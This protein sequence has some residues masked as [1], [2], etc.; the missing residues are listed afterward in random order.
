MLFSGY[1]GCGNPGDEAILQATVD[2][3]RKEGVVD[4][5]VLSRNLQEASQM[6]LRG[7]LRES[8]TGVLQGISR[9]RVLMSGGGGLLQ[10]STG[11]RSLLYYLGIIFL[12]KMMGKQ[13]GIYAQGIGPIRGS[14]AR[15]LTRLVLNRVDGITVRDR[16]SKDLLQEIGVRLPVEVTA[17][18]AL[19]LSVA[20]REEGEAVLSRL[21]VQPSPSGSRPRVLGAVV[22]RWPTWSARKE[23]IGGGIRQ[24]LQEGAVTDLVLIPFQPSLD[25][26]CCQEIQEV[27]G[28]KILEESLP[29]KL[30]ASLLG[31]MEMVVSMRLH[32]LIFSAIQGVPCLGISYDPKVSEFCREVGAPT[33]SLDGLTASQ[34]GLELRSLWVNRETIGREMREKTETL[35]EKGRRNIEFLRGFVGG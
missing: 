17:D 19:L 20:P 30:M 14:L 3:L 29:V 9:C 5:G 16:A 28:G 32:A 24:F 11:F 2:S 22:R 7:Y 35:Q 18:P 23:E 10:D 8:W 25:L 21:G 27:T 34:L 26:R 4:L 12:G 31:T 1:Y 6:G 15:L 33:L 13:T